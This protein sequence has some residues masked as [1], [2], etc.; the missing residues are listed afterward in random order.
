MSEII[1][2]KRETKETS[3]VVEL[4]MEERGKI[5]IDT[6]LPFFDHMLHAMAFHGG[7]SLTITAKGD[8][9]VDPHHLVEDT[10]LV[11]GQ[12]FMEYFKK[13]GPFERYSHCV[14]P[15]DDSLA[16]VTID[17]CNRPYLVHNIDYPQDRSGEF[18]MF[19]LKEFFQAFVSNSRINLHINCPYGENSHH[20]SEAIFKSMGIALKK[21]FTRIS[22]KD[23]NLSTKGVF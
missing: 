5:A 22:R 13:S 12:A 11:L 15:M 4:D 2:V 17:A 18:D 14:I 16:E 20:L 8:T 21:S 6:T 10:G 19:L 1:T 7:F 3:I 23:G 9:H